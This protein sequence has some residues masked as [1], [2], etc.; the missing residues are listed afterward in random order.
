M[1]LVVGKRGIVPL[2]T[3][4]PT[5]LHGLSDMVPTRVFAGGK[6]PVPAPHHFIFSMFRSARPNRK[7]YSADSTFWMPAAS[8]TKPGTN[9]AGLPPK[10]WMP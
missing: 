4:G 5:H 3:A 1:H 10:L 2:N 6:A 9:G 8:V 7:M